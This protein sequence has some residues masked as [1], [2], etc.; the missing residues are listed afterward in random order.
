GKLGTNSINFSST[1]GTSAPPNL[2]NLRS[3]NAAESID[4]EK[5]LFDNNLFYD[6][7]SGSRAPN[8]SDAIMTMFR[9]KRGEISLAEENSI[10]SQLGQ[11]D[12]RQ[13]IR[14]QLLQAAQS[15]QYNLSFNG[16]VQGA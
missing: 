16:A 11:M 7:T 13:Q 8:R 12:N 3:M 14:D 10:L 6:P 4:F 9:A 1:L 2:H 15:Q 5:E